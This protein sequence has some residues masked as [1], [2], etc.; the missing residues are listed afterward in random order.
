MTQQERRRAPRIPLNRSILAHLP[1]QE[2]VFWTTSDI[3][4]EGV[5]FYAQQALPE[6]AVLK[7]HLEVPDPEHHF[8]PVE[9]EGVISHCVDTHENGY[10][11]GL[12]FPHPPETYQQLVTQLEQ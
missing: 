10:H 2:T 9:L 8:H 6:G 5:G 11:I 3:S 4:R 12:H 1:N 7:I